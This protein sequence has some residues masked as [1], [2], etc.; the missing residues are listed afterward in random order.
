MC[1]SFEFPLLQHKNVLEYSYLKGKTDLLEYLLQHFVFI[2]YF[3][4][5][6]WKNILSVRR[7]KMA[8]IIVVVFYMYSAFS[9]S[10]L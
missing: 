1:T 5:A 2:F 4:I 10:G 3:L 6:M 8:V 9:D 7:F